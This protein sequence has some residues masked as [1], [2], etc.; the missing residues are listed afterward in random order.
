MLKLRYIQS[1]LRI[2]N[3]GVFGSIPQLKANLLHEISSLDAK[4]SD[5]GFSTEEVINGRSKQGILQDIVS[6][7][8][9]V[10]DKNLEFNG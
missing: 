8:D 3:K 2:W 1:K 5:C 7:E 4:E 9:K 10:G 6:K